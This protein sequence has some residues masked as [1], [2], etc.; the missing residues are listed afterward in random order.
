L[1]TAFGPDQ[2]RDFPAHRYVGAG[3]DFTPDGSTMVS[4]IWAAEDE[5]TQRLGHRS[6]AADIL[7]WPK[8][9]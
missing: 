6:T 7:E 8:W 3:V 2:A 5:K 4:F 9:T 1:K